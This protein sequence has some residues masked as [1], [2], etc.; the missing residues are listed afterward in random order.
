MILN[1]ENLQSDSDNTAPYHASLYRDHPPTYT[2]ARISTIQL[3]SIV[4]YLVLPP[5]ISLN[6]CP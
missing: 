5:S 6:F 1:R 4:M 3:H 2:R